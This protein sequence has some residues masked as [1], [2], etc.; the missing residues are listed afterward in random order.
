[1]HVIWSPELILS[2][3]TYWFLIRIIYLCK[4]HT[5]Y[6]IGKKYFILWSIKQAKEVITRAAILVV[7]SARYQA[8][9]NPEFSNFS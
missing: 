1:M 7:P 4:L 3:N 8:A 2:C 9:F 5:L 6:F